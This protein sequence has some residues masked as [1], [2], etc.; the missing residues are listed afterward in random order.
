MRCN[1][2]IWFNYTVH[3][4]NIATAKGKDLNLYV[5]YKKSF[6]LKEIKMF[7]Q[8]QGDFIAEIDLVGEKSSNTNY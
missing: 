3:T 6:I 4:A 1:P 7:S 5:V 8:E 2:Q